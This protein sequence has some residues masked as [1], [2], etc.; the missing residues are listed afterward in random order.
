MYAH[1]GHTLV[2]GH[3]IT[4]LDNQITVDVF[5]YYVIMY[6]ILDRQK[7]IVKME[8]TLVYWILLPW[9]EVYLGASPKTWDVSVLLAIWILGS[10]S[11]KF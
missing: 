2:G 9:M 10:R 7:N 5:G 6:Y 4:I 1:L 11:C 3:S 8:D